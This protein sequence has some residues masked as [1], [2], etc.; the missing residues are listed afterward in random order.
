MAFRVAFQASLAVGWAVPQWLVVLQ[1]ALVMAAYRAAFRV[2]TMLGLAV[3][4]EGALLEVER[5]DL[6]AGPN[7]VVDQSLSA[8]V[9]V[10]S[11]PVV[12]Q[13]ASFLAVRVSAF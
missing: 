6:A 11:I 1:L 13:A 9:P 3:H 2:V 8:V 4:L 10:V 7:S 12:A 5:M